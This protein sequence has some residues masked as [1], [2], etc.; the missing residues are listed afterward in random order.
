MVLLERYVLG[1]L[2]MRTGPD[3]NGWIRLIQTLIDGI[4]LL[5]KKNYGTYFSSVLFF[6]ICTNLC[7]IVSIGVL[8]VSL[9]V[10]SVLMLCSSVIT[11]CQYGILRGL[12]VLGVMLGFDIVMGTSFMRNNRASYIVLVFLML[13]ESGRTPVDTIEGESELVSRFNTE[14]GRLGFV[15]FFLGEYLMILLFFWSIIRMAS[16]FIRVLFVLLI[17]GVLPRMKYIEVVQI[18]WRYL[19]LVVL[20]L[21][22]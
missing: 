18:C 21:I 22:L 17:R 13:C 8:L 14:F 7:S 1:G 6:G 2:Q 10:L 20:I 15:F 19:F 12:R 16:S 4:K 5:G 11:N 9:T 3:V